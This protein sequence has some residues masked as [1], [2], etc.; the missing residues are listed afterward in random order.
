LPVGCIALLGRFDIGPPKLQ[1]LT[2]YGNH[3]DLRSAEFPRLVLRKIYHQWLFK[4]PGL[5]VS[6]FDIAGSLGAYN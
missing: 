2:A 5:Y 3:V 4:V 6:V 1:Y